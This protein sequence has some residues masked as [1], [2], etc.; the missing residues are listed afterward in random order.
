MKLI[1]INENDFNNLAITFETKNFFQT[2]N[3]GKYLKKKGNDVFYVG[4]FDNNKCLACAMLN[5]DY[6]FLGKNHFNCLKG[7]LC[8]Y[9]NEKVVCEFVREL[10]SFITSHNG[11]GIKISPYV[12]LCSK[13]IDGNDVEGF[14]NRFIIKQVE[15]FGFEKCKNDVNVKTVFCTDIKDYNESE[16]FATFKQNT[17]NLIHRAQSMGVEIEDLKVNQLDRFKKITEYV[18]NKRGF[19]DKSLSYYQDM[20]NLF[21]SEVVFKIAKLNV[22]KYKEYLFELKKDL[23]KKIDNI[24]KDNSKKQN[25]IF[26]LENV[27]KKI[28]ESQNFNNDFIDLACAMFML[29]GD[30]TVYLF[31]GS[32][33]EYNEFAGQY[34]IQWDIFKYAIEHKMKRHNFYGVLNYKDKSSKDY[35]VYLFKRGFGGYIE[36]LIGEYEWLSKSFVSAIYRIKNR[37]RGN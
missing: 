32:Y 34:L 18:C 26:E 4:L 1:E 30:E 6:S 37:F 5:V 24:K 25:Y 15:S 28:E 27:N 3:M 19:S 14:D 12:S 31:S 21:G 29:Y 2:S 33:D 36:E 10:K 11:F 17:R 16:L 20:F 7:F 35:G 9:S 13:D 23:K 8:D 22:N